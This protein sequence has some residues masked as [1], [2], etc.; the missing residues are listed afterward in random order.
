MDLWTPRQGE[1]MLPD[2]ADLIAPQVSASA[3]GIVAAG[4]PGVA[5][6]RGGGYDEH[7]VQEKWQAGAV[8]CS[9]QRDLSCAIGP[10]L[11]TVKGN[12]ASRS[13]IPC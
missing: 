10:S 3:G 12:A 6:E 9:G 7:K 4:A 1:L 5:V 13:S 8:R 11:S 2:A